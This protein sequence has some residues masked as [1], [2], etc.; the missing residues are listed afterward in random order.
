MAF[1]ENDPEP[2]SWLAGF[3]KALADLGWTDGRNLSMAPATR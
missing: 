1:A 3:M 2:K